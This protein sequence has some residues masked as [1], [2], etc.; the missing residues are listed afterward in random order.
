MLSKF[1]LLKMNVEIFFP[2][3]PCYETTLSKTI[4]YIFLY[5]SVIKSPLY[6]NIKIVKKI[7]SVME[8]KTTETF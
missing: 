5:I 3:I 6:G 8:I 7:Y 1:L 4:L 2:N